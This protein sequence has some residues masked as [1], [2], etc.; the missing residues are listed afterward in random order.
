MISGLRA[1]FVWYAIF[2]VLLSVNV[3]FVLCLLKRPPLRKGSFGHSARVPLTADR[4]AG[5]PVHAHV[6]RRRK[7]PKNLT[8]GWEFSHIGSHHSPL[9]FSCWTARHLPSC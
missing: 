3:F 6:T 9:L 1:S 8:K 2:D 5:A 7:V 4:Y